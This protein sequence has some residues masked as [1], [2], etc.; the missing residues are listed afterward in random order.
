MI[1]ESE[2]NSEDSKHLFMLL[3]DQNFTQTSLR[4][5]AIDSMNMAGSAKNVARLNT[6]AIEAAKFF[7]IAKNE[8]IDGKQSNIFATFSYQT[9]PT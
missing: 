8:D 5:G 4:I 6:K 7:Q 9:S 1:T 2:T 3:K